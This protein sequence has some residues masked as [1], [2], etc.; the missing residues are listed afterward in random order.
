V[1]DVYV[2]HVGVIK[3]VGPHFGNEVSSALSDHWKVAFRVVR[4]HYKRYVELFHVGSANGTPGQVLSSVQAGQ[5]DAGQQ[6]DNGNYDK[7]FYERKTA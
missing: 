5:Q 2:G 1:K 6:R 3:L 4:V 7:Q